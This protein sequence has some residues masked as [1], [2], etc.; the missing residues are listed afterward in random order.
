MWGEHPGYLH[1]LSRRLPHAPAGTM[2]LCNACAIER[3]L[4]EQVEYL[5]FGF[6]P[7]IVDDRATPQEN[8]LLA[9]MVRLLGRYGHRLYPAHSQEQ[10]KRK[11]GPTLIEREWLALQP[12]VWRA[13]VDVLRL[14]R[15]V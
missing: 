10:Y 4:S 3:F 2:E 12:P 5:H 9:W 11:W 6:T 1:D 13:I 8:R 15:A 14:T 7:F